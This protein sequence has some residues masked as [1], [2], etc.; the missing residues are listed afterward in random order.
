MNTE[1]V[2]YGQSHFSRNI[3]VTGNL[4]SSAI[5]YK[6][7]VFEIYSFFIGN[8]RDW[9]GSVAR[10]ACVPPDSIQSFLQKEHG[11]NPFSSR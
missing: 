10:L 9:H 4:F 7:L 3:V 8:A 11:M 5:P 6:D 1:M 2:M